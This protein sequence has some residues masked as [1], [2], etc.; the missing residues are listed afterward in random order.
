MQS[1]MAPFLQRQSNKGE[2]VLLFCLVSV[3]LPP[4]LWQS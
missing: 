3:D 2:Q 4:Y 1:Y